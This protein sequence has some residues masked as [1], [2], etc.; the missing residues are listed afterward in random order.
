VRT[1]LIFGRY[2]PAARPD[3]AYIKTLLAWS[4]RPSGVRM[5]NRWQ[6]ALL[7]VI[8]IAV[9]AATVVV[10]WILADSYARD[11]ATR[12]TAIGA[13]LVGA[14]LLI[15]LFGLPVAISQL[16]AVKRDLDLITGISNVERELIGHIE[17]GALIALSMHDLEEGHLLD[18]VS[19]GLSVGTYPDW[20]E[21]VGEF[22]RTNG[23]HAG[24]AEQYLFQLAGRGK[25][26]HEELEI[27]LAYLRDNVLP[28][29][30]A[31]YW[32]DRP[33]VIR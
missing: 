1:P 16:F 13:V 28:K 26:A 4:R 2:L 30:R 22:I 8:P 3:E 5:L 24:P 33:P 27:R 12:W 6:H 9:G 7:W 10:V 29:V 23:G 21:K 19:Q 17:E 14:A 20:V 32:I 31:G 15:A 18:F 11:T 25:L